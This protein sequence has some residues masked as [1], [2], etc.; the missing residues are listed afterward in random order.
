[1]SASKADAL[2]RSLGHALRFLER[3]LATPP[4]EIQRAAA[5][6]AFECTYELSWKLLQAR[7]RDEGVAVATPRATFR[8]AGDAGLV[9]SVEPWLDYLDV[10]NLTSHTYNEATA[11]QVYAVISA[12]FVEDVHSLLASER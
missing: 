2:A 1:M 12:A 9:A 7:L 6:Q 4:D 10:R 11:E 3:V 5:I 8:A